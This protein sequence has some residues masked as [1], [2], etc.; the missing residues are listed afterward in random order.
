MP[1][2]SSYDTECF[3]SAQVALH[4]VDWRMVLPIAMAQ[5]GTRENGEPVASATAHVLNSILWVWA[6]IYSAFRAGISASFFL[7]PSK[8]PL[9][10]CLHFRGSFLVIHCYGTQGDI[11]D[12]HRFRN[13]EKKI[14]KLSD[15]KWGSVFFLLTWL[16]PCSLVPSFM[17][18]LKLSSFSLHS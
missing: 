8:N 10:S 16:T 5:V 12:I 17:S 14:Y 9:L 1:R 4:F 7:S 18:M 3:W 2:V 15:L 6:V 11:M 13:C